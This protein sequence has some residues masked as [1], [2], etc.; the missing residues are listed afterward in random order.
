MATLT[1]RLLNHVTLSDGDTMAAESAADLGDGHTLEA[2]I[3]VHAACEGDAPALVLKH[4][5]DSADPDWLDFPEPMK[6][7]LTRSGRFWLHADR[8]T[9]YVGWSLSGT[10][11]SSPEVTIDLLAKG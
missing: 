5:P 4:A 6:V 11:T 8:Y 2:V 1:S 3:T 10:L 7:S 9:R